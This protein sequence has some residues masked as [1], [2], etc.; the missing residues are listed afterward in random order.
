[1]E[2]AGIAGDAKKEG[3]MFEAAMAKARADAELSAEH[4]AITV[5]RH[6]AESSMQQA[7][8][9]LER[10]RLTAQTEAYVEQVKAVSPEL[11]AKLQ[12][13]ADVILS[14]TLFENFDQLALLQGQTLPDVLA[15]FARG[16]PGLENALKLLPTQV[17]VSG[18]EG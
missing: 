6:E 18:A 12:G 7:E 17:E 11:A 13:L 14:A 15:Q 8:F 10:E 3:H 4:T 9:A 2:I 1:M 16:V 5:S